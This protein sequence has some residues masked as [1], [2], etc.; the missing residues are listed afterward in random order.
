MKEDFYQFTLPNGIKVIHQPTL[1]MASHIGVFIDSGTRDEEHDQHGLAH[2]IEHCLFKGTKNRKA[3][4]ILS[5]L[6]TVGGELN[7][8]T[9]K[10]DTTY[11]ASFL[12]E[13]YERA[14]ELLSD[15]TFSS[16]FPEKEIIK[17]K[18]IIIDEIYS[19]LDSPGEQIF[20]DFEDLIFNQHELGKSILGTSENL[21]KYKRN[22]LLRYY[23]KHYVSQNTTIASVGNIASEKLERLIRKYFENIPSLSI[24]KKRLAFVPNATVHK[25][26][27]KEITQAHL[28]LGAPA[29]GNT[30]EKRR[31]LILLN[32][33]LGGPA[34][35]S[36]LNLNISEKYG[37]AYNLESN[38]TPYSDT[39]F[40][41]VY[42][43]TEEKAIEKATKLIHKELKKLQE[44]RLGV[45]QLHQAKQQLKG[46]IA[47]GQESGSALM[48][49]LGKSLQIYDKVDPL[50]QVYQEID[51]VTSLQLLEI[52]NEI[53]DQR[54]LSSLTYLPT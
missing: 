41:S 36:R 21:K 10:E 52:A 24:Q 49:T 23:A 17:E 26:V 1:G 8:F 27:D 7:A 40:F 5:R 31:P 2:Y 48:L 13:H 14:I 51:Q 9:S 35:N 6:D 45:N 11:Y 28:M 15:I 30:N 16:N 47:L 3:Y 18:L 20:D 38:Y 54:N 46:Q 39:G 4:H 44:V 12:H 32:N 22:D 34:M 19:Y 50:R 42:I 29:Y 37:F 25:S 33:L 53:F 43:G